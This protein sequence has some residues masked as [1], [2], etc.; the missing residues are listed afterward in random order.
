M[1][2]R[3]NSFIS[4]NYPARTAPHIPAADSARPHNLADGGRLFADMLLPFLHTET[5]RFPL[6][7][8]TALKELRFL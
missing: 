2:G 3:I 5:G 6:G 4:E 7:F 1:S 8:P